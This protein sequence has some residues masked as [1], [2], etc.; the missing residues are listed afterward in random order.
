MENLGRNIIGIRS[1]YIKVHNSFT[2]SNHPQSVE[3]LNHKVIM[4]KLDCKLSSRSEFT[5]TNSKINL[6]AGTKRTP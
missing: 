4:G 2:P 5:N 3:F 6:N 1:K